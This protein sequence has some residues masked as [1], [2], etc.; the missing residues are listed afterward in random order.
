[1]VM[2]VYRLP[3]GPVA[4]V[5]AVL[6]SNTILLYR[7][8]IRSF[9]PSLRPPFRPPR[10]S[11][12]TSQA[13]LQTCSFLPPVLA[14]PRPCR[15]SAGAN[16]TQSHRHHQHRI[17]G[18]PVGRSQAARSETELRSHWNHQQ[19]DLGASDQLER[20]GTPDPV[21]SNAVK[22]RFHDARAYAAGGR[23]DAAYR[24]AGVACGR[25]RCAA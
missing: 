22:S 25:A 14:V 12:Q 2:G 1:V 4:G 13:S 10:P 18:Q 6:Y 20:H 21:R 3:P 7:F 5:M 11:L 19:R 8:Y 15:W 24:Q 9:R 16:P 17:P 23:A